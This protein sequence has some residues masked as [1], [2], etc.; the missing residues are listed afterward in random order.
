MTGK[1]PTRIVYNARPKSAQ[2]KVRQCP[3]CFGSGRSHRGGPCTYCRA[4]GQ[5]SGLSATGAR[6]NAVG[7][8]ITSLVWS[9]FLLAILIAVLIAVL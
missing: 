1:P 9:V 5:V 4:T 8:T 2:A 6:I 7:R 3:V